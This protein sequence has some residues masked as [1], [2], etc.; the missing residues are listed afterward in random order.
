MCCCRVAGTDINKDKSSQRKL[1]EAGGPLAN[2]PRTLHPTHIE[3]RLKDD[4]HLRSGKIQEV[5]IQS[6][7]AC[8]LTSLFFGRQYFTTEF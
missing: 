1:S 3:K 7:T 2:A 8:Y 6:K 4:R 5:I